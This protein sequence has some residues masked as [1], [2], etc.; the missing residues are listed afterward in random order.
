MKQIANPRRKVQRKPT[1][2]ILYRRNPTFDELVRFVGEVG[3]KRLEL[4]Q[5]HFVNTRSASIAAE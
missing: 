1:S 2:R 3:A 5:Q 4:A